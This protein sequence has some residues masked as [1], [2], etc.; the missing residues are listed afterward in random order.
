MSAEIFA[1]EPITNRLTISAYNVTSSL[2][3]NYGAVN[4]D[5]VFEVLL[6][7]GSAVSTTTSGNT[8][9]LSFDWEFSKDGAVV[10]TTS[11]KPFISTVN[12]R[13]ISLSCGVAL[14]WF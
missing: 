14:L 13:V 5:S 9:F 10:H 12:A 7:D 8:S 3:S 2:G 1:A 11:G 4:E 6:D